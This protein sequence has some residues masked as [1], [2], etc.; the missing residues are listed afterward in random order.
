MLNRRRLKVFAAE[1]ANIP[2]SLKTTAVQDQRKVLKDKVQNW[3]AVRAVYMPGLLQIQTDAGFNPTAIWNSNPN[4]EDVQLWLPSEIATNQRRAAC[5]EGLPEIE[6]RLRTA[7]CGSSLEGLRQ[8][9]RVKTRMVYFKNKNIRGQREGTRSRSIIDRVH[10]RAIDFVQ[11]YR[12][13]RHAKLNLEGPGI[14]EETYRELRNE[15]IRGFASGKPKKNPPRRGIWEDGY[16]PQE[17]E[18]TEIFDEAE[19]ESDPELDDP[20][21]R[22]LPP[23]KKRK[24]GTG[25]TRKQ[26]SWIWQTLPLNLDA[27]E[28]DNIL[29][30]EW[31]RSRARV[32]R[33]TE[34]AML[35][36]EEMRR[37]LAFLKWKASWWDNR[38]DI[39]SD[40]PTEM[41]EGLCAYASRQ[42]NL[43]RALA[44][45]FKE[46]WKTPLAHVS[47]LLHGLETT[48]HPIDDPDDEPDDENSDAEETTELGLNNSNDYR[49]GS[50][51]VDE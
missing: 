46:L 47:D 30:A 11:K 13:A 45:F 35:L 33:A 25:E 6:L 3:E 7:Q 51:V 16:G 10:K 43:Q 48:E 17:P 12:A 29:R 20:T 44:A 5:I 22:G 8:A 23:R 40:A 24:K 34:E 21:E 31:A 41:R 19:E 27:E 18:A 36:R 39:R 38:Q 14:W 15:D 50:D 28:D 32:R 42:A 9:L 1:Q 37:A 26:L 4:P 49:E 2:K